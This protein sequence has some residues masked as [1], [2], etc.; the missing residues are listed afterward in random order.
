MFILQIKIQDAVNLLRATINKLSEV[1]KLNKKQKDDDKPEVKLDEFVPVKETSVARS[2]KEL[3]LL[4][5]AFISEELGSNKEFRGFLSELK[6]NLVEAVQGNMSAKLSNN[7]FTSYLTECMKGL[8]DYCNQ[9]KDEETPSG[10]MP[11]AEAINVLSTISSA[12]PLTQVFKLLSIAKNPRF[13]D[14]IRAVAASLVNDALSHMKGQ[15]VE[16]K[17]AKVLL[18]L[19]SSAPDDVRGL[20]YAAL[21]DARKIEEDSS[22]KSVMN[23]NF[24]HRGLLNRNLTLA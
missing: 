18:A 22:K 7:S 17:T 1:A 12:H 4:L 2:L 13:P 21:K 3:I 14:E 15:Y 9:K 20:L 16:A 24:S 5:I 23:T 10:K 19:I 6:N 8:L 11:L